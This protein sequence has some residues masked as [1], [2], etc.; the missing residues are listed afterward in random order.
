[1][2]SKALVVSA[3]CYQR[4]IEKQ[5]VRTCN[6]GRRSSGFAYGRFSDM[7]SQALSVQ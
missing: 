3:L 7:T 4:K 1:M 5:A 2:I 6:A